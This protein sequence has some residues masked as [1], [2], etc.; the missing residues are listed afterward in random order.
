[1]KLRHHHVNT[2]LYKTKGFQKIKNPD[3]KK[4]GIIK[5]ITVLMK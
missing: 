5:V 1:M 4:S 2:K 3:Y